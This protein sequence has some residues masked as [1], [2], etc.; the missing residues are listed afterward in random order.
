MCQDLRVG[1]RQAHGR[2]NEGQPLLTKLIAHEGQ[3]SPGPGNVKNLG[4]GV[5]RHWPPAP[6]L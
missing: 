5:S 1:P 4:I 2:V 6:S 3:P